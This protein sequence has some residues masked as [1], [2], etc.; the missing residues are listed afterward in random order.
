MHQPLLAQTNSLELESENG[1][2]D[3]KLIE[4]IVLLENLV[5]QP[6]NINHVAFDENYIVTGSLL[7]SVVILYDRK[8]GEQLNLIGRSGDGPFEYQRVTHIQLVN[9]K[10]YLNCAENGLIAYQL[11]GKGISQVIY[12]SQFVSNFYVD[13]SENVFAVY[14]NQS[15]DNFFIDIFDF[16]GQKQSSNLGVG[17]DNERWLS[18]FT[19]GGGIYLDTPNLIYVLKD[20]N[21]IVRHNINT[22]V[23]ESV[24]LKNERFKSPPLTK[25]SEQMRSDPTALFDF[26]LNRSMGSSLYKYENYYFHEIDH[27]DK[28][29]SNYSEFQILNDNF[30]QL[31]SIVIDNPTTKLLNEFSLN[32]FKNQIAYF[33]ADEVTDRNLLFIVEINK[34]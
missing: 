9:N 32:S 31:D 19:N 5:P 2:F 33:R 24:T 1:L 21:K 23:S 22:G 13:D 27:R 17:N 29:T 14:N 3:F 10:I 18:P 34:K 28:Q 11:D 16:D 20:E 4:E 25:S 12:P 15:D 6:V 7:Q 30:E 26:I 8:T